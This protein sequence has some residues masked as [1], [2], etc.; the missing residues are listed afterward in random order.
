LR[1][2]VNSTGQRPAKPCRGE[3]NPYLRITP[4]QGLGKD[5]PFRRA[6]FC[7]VDFKDF[8]LNLSGLQ[9]YFLSKTQVIHKNGREAGFSRGFLPSTPFAAGKERLR[10]APVSKRLFW[11]VSGLRYL[12]M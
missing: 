7:T 5:C 12:C 8:S 10:F 4:R 1:Q 6:P 9:G 11:I 3:I 2:P